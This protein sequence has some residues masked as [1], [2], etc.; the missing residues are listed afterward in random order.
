MLSKGT[1]TATIMCEYLDFKGSP[2][3]TAM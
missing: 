3:V 2:T 1:R